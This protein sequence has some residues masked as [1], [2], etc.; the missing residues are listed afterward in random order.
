MQTLGIFHCFVHFQLE[1]SQR[2]SYVEQGDLAGAIEQHPLNRE[3]DRV[4][5]ELELT[6]KKAIQLEQ[7]V[8]D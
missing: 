5:Q 8:N 1:K 7:R 2:P 6:E 4:R 3:I